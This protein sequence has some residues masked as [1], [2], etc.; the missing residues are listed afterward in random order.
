MEARQPQQ[1][2]PIRYAA[3]RLAKAAANLRAADDQLVALG[4]ELRQTPTGKRDTTFERDG[5][6]AL[7]HCVAVSEAYREMR[8]AE[9]DFER[10]T[11]AGSGQSVDDAIAAREHTRR[12]LDGTR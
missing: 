10:L 8:E 12:R 11:A 5:D 1:Q 7:R 9:A 4:K 6:L 2:D 3:M